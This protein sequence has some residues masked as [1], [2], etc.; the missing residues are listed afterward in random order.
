LVSTLPVHLFKAVNGLST[1]LSGG[2]VFIAV[3]VLH[4]VLL[5]SASVVRVISSKV[6]VVRSGSVL[7]ISVDGLVDVLQTSLLH[8]VLVLG[9]VAAT[10]VLIWLK[11]LTQFRMVSL[12]VVLV[13]SLVLVVALLIEFL[14]SLPVVTTIV[15]A[16]V[17]VEAIDAHLLLVLGF[18]DLEVSPLGQDLHSL[19]VL[20]GG[21]LLPVVLVTTERVKVDLLAQALVLG[22]DK[23]QDVDDLLTVQNLV[24]IHTSDRVENGPHNLWIV[25]S[26]EMISDVEAE[27][28]LVQLGFLDSDA[29]IAQWWWQLS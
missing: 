19:D 18:D 27:N 2:L 3:R 14:S 8:P 16:V 17:D 23:L 28:N 12:P 15:V 25:H 1:S 10:V 26:S 29:L 21:K 6:A 7:P 4:D 9:A 11:L 22:L 13:H 24:V 20:D 5:A